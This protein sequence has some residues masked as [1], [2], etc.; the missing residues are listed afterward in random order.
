[1]NE[2]NYLDL[3]DMY[4]EKIKY[5][6]IDI[7]LMRESILH[8][9]EEIRKLKKELKQKQAEGCFVHCEKND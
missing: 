6:H 7:D 8:H 4:K 2:E 1:M 5:K 3:I 9:T